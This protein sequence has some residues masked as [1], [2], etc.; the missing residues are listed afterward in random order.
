MCRGHAGEYLRKKF[1]KRPL[2]SGEIE[3]RKKMNCERVRRLAPDCLS[4]NNLRRRIL[5]DDGIFEESAYL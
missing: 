3:L 5:G 2:Y 4:Y 1:A